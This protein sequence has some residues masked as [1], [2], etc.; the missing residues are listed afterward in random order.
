M[1]SVSVAGVMAIGMR[2][3]RAASFAN[4]ILFQVAKMSNAAK[5]SG[6]RLIRRGSQL[7]RPNANVHPVAADE[8]TISKTHP[9]RLGCNILLGVCYEWWTV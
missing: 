7:R 8:S 1:L 2:A 3:F 6:T 9:P 5:S 4:V